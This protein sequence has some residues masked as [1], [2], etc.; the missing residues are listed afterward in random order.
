[1]KHQQY[2]NER[3]TYEVSWHQGEEEEGPWHHCQEEEG[4]EDRHQEEGEEEE[5]HCQ[6]EEEDHH[7]EEGVEEGDHLMGYLLMV[8]W[9]QRKRLQVLVGGMGGAWLRLLVR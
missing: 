4:E 1:M 2:E 3:N 6:E 5:D 8:L 9:N 7:Q